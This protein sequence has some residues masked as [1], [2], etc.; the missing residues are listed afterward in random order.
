MK[1]VSAPAS[2]VSAA[3]ATSPPKSEKVSTPVVTPVKAVQPAPKSQVVLSSCESYKPLFEQYD[4]NVNV[5]MAIM[6]AES[7]CN[8]SAI[9]P[10]NSDG[11]RDYG[12]M[13]LHGMDILNPAQNIEAAYRQK[14]LTQGWRAWSTYKSGKYLNYLQ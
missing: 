1:T 3:A 7:S 13:Q 10:V 6:Q 8:A 2:K 5:A 9:S 11:V 14:Y 12:L 4:W